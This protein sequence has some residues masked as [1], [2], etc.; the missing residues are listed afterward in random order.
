MK[1]C[2]EMTESLARRYAAYRLRQ[3]KRRRVLFLGGGLLVA[4]V[5]SVGLIFTS[6]WEYPERQV[7]DGG[8]IQSGGT[9]L[10][11]LPE[12]DG[13]AFAIRLTGEAEAITPAACTAY[14]EE[15][16]FA[17]KTELTVSGV[18]AEKLRFGQGYHHLRLD[19]GEVAMDWMDVLLY[20]GDDLVGI[21]TLYQEDG[22]IFHSLLFG[23][24]WFS[25]LEDYLR[26]QKGNRLLMV[27]V[28]ELEFLI[29]EKGTF[30]SPLGPDTESLLGLDTSV[31]YYTACYCEE[32]IMIP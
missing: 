10:P 12:S 31:N 2:D 21:A 9:D 29:D 1:T 32:A 5:L 15:N 22:R 19:T 26:L 14:L 8:D 6:P 24:P 28:G 16:R 3:K 23:S 20:N 27:Y 11:T 17:L 18:A 7:P 4:A 13:S 30:K 25:E